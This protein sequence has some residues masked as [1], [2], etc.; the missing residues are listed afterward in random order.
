M[1]GSAQELK[2]MYPKHVPIPS[3]AL[4]FIELSPIKVLE[5]NI[6][7][8]FPLKSLLVSPLSTDSY[9]VSAL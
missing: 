9:Q 8:M 1:T 4:P 3:R 5:V 2:L 7:V 6:V